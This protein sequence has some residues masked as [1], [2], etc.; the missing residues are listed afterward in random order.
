MREREKV[1]SVFNFASPILWYPKWSTFAHFGG[2][3]GY[4]KE[5]FRSPKQ[6]ET[7]FIDQITPLKLGKFTS[8]IHF[9]YWKIRDHFY[10]P[11]TFA[12]FGGFGWYQ[13]EHVRSPKPKSQITFIDQITPQNLGKITLG[14]RFGHLKV[15]FWP[16]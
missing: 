15:V 8:G 7:T 3:G 10:R 5:H 4:Q 13:K 1:I 14:T 16:F 12:H 6:N 9:P 2:F 11:G